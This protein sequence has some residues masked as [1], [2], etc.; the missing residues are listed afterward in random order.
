MSLPEVKATYSARAIGCYFGK[1]GEDGTGNAQVFV[2]FRISFEDGDEHITWAG[3]LTSDGGKAFEIA[4]KA[5]RTLGWQGDDLTELEDLDE[6]GAAKLL[7]N[8]VEIV[9]D[10]DEYNGERKLKVKWVNAPGGG[11]MTKHALAGADLK[12]FA[13]QMRGTI[14]SMAVPRSAGSS[15][16]SAPQQRSGGGGRDP[17]PNAPGGPR[18]RDDIPF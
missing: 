15:R 9:C 6:D 16:P 18:D 1:A 7:P 8:Q 3:T 2:P 10:M 13:A 11:K 17:H 4:I 5:L 12:T 14:R